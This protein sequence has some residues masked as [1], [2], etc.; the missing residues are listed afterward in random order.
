MSPGV[1]RNQVK[2]QRGDVPGVVVTPVMPPFELQSGDVKGLRH[3][4]PL[5]KVVCFGEP[6]LGVGVVATEGIFGVDV[7]ALTRELVAVV[8]TPARPRRRVG[9]VFLG[10]NPASVGECDALVGFLGCDT[11]QLGAEVADGRPLRPH[12]DPVLGQP[13]PLVEVDDREPDLDDLAHLPGRRLPLPTGGL[14][15]DDV[16]QTHTMSLGTLKQER[17]QFS[18]RSAWDGEDDRRPLAVPNSSKVTPK[19]DTVARVARQ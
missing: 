13:G 2:N 11:G 16:D 17:N 14:D 19:L 6:Q 10:E 1:V 5:A 8:V 4:R 15:I 3:T 9:L 7:L 18:S 12:H